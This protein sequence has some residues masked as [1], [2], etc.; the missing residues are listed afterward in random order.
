MMGTAAGTTTAPPGPQFAVT[1]GP[2]GVATLPSAIAMKRDPLGFVLAAMRRYGDVTRFKVPGRTIFLLAGPDAARHVLCEHHANYDKG[3]GLDEVRAWLGDGVLT[4]DGAAWMQ[5]RRR[6]QPLF[7]HERRATFEAAVVAAAQ[8]T[9]RRWSA[10][11]G[12][13]AIDIVEEMDRLTLNVA[14]GIFLQAD[15]DPVARLVSQQFATLSSYAMTRATALCAVPAWVPT[16]GSVRAARARRS[17]RRVVE[18]TRVSAGAPSREELATLL[19]AGYDTSAATLSWTWHLL[20]RHPEVRA[21]VERELETIPQPGAV[22]MESL[23]Y[24]RQVVDEVLRLFPPVWIL[25][26][27]SKTGDRIAGYEVPAGA[28]VLVCVAALHRNAAY[29]TDPD[30]FDPSRFDPQCGARRHP[31]AYL[32]FG[33]GPRACIGSQLGTME[34]LLAACLLARQFRLDAISEALPAPV[35]GLT[36]RPGG[37]RQLRLHSRRASA[38]GFRRIDHEARACV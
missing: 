3:I 6:V 33:A 16:I 11:R 30:R 2:R 15:L 5:S 23:P 36:L 7:D 21:R 18:A 9:A 35:A 8:S 29:W 13:T 26:R 12:D 38:V 28:D 37:R 1:P 24:L 25:P 27:R 14:G 32:P 34:V 31:F 10:A 20:A 19:M 22:A 17:L 4:G